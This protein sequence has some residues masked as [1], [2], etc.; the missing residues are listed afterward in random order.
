MNEVKYWRYIG[1]NARAAPRTMAFT[2]VWNLSL[3]LESH[4][5]ITLSNDHARKSLL[6][7][8]RLNHDQPMFPMKRPITI[9]QRSRLLGSSTVA[10]A[11]GTVES[12]EPPPPLWIA[13]ASMNGSPTT[14]S[15]M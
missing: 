10:K 3:T 12:G 14:L 1:I 5:G 2:G 4:C 9:S 6:M 13:Q 15:S 8:T 11:V 7:K